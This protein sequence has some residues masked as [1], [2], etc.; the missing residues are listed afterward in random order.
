MNKNSL[1][2]V[3]GVVLAVVIAWWIVSALF[4]ILWFIAKLAIVLVVAGVVFLVLRGLFS[5]KA[6]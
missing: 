5:S 1:W 4:S 3:I 2:T 6:E